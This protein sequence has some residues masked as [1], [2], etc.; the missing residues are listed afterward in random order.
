MTWVR[1]LAGANLGVSL[2][3]VSWLWDFW[4]PRCNESCEPWVQLSM[5]GTFLVIPAMAAVLAL[6]TVRRRF[7]VRRGLG[8]CAVC[9]VCLLGWVE[10]L[11]RQ[12]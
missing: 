8:A 10:F 12:G 9:A 3:A 1:L 5:Y 6:L 2:A 4:T 11:A 7:S